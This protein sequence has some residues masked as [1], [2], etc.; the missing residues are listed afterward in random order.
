M[1]S[2]ACSEEAE[3]QKQHPP[4]NSRGDATGDTGALTWHGVSAFSPVQLLSVEEMACR[5]ASQRRTAV[6][7]RADALRDAAN[8]G[9]GLISAVPAPLLLKRHSC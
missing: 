2:A 7:N 8:A 4:G 6:H 3:D 9:M 1:G 5:T